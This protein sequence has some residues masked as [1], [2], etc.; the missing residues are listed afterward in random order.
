MQFDG[1]LVEYRS[2]GS[3]PLWATG[4]SG[5]F[6]AYA[7]MQV[8]GD[9]VVYPHGESAPATGRPTP[10]LWSTGTYG[11]RGSALELLD[12]GVIVVRGPNQG[13]VRWTSG[14]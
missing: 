5:N 4:T 6:G 13:A 3:A 9:F 11:L 8:D 12:D 7:V 2:H 10:A 1:N 14:G